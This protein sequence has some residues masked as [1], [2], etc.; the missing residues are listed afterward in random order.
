MRLRTLPVLLLVL[1]CLGVAPRAPAAG[2]RTGPS[3]APSAAQK[4]Y[5]V[6]L[7]YRQQL[8]QQVR[9]SSP[10]STAPALP[11]RP[12]DDLPGRLADGAPPL[13][14]GTV[15]LSLLQRLQP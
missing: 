1:L 15:L 13:P 2:G 10:H 11:A 9:L 6:A 3:R 4:V 12:A 14:A 7:R 8:N 5:P